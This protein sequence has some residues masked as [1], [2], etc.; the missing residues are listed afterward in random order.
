MSKIEE[1]KTTAKALIKKGKAI[2]DFAKVK[3]G[4]IA[5]ALIDKFE[6]KAKEA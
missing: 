6:Q 5:L 1:L 2:K 3:R 4:V